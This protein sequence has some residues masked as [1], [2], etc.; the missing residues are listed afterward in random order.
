M[1]SIN[2]AAEMLFGK[3]IKHLRKYALQNIYIAC[4]TVKFI[5]HSLT[6]RYLT[7]YLIWWSVCSTKCGKG[8]QGWH[9]VQSFYWVEESEMKSHR[10][11]NLPYFLSLAHT[12]IH[13]EASWC[14]YGIHGANWISTDC[15]TINLQWTSRLGCVKVGHIDPQSC[16]I[17]V[18]PWI[19]FSLEKK[20]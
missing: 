16:R 19:K 12:H 13:I 18:Q 6:V 4:L 11:P 8:P 7:W 17:S 15:Y 5:P 10:S 1:R 3:H 20:S 9:L 14:M 2:S